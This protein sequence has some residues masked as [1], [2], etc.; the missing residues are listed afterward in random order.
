[1]THRGVS[2][3]SPQEIVPQEIVPQATGDPSHTPTPTLN[4]IDHL[5]RDNHSPSSLSFLDLHTTTTNGP[6]PPKQQARTADRDTDCSLSDNE[7]SRNL[8]R[9]ELRGTTKL[10]SSVL[11]IDIGGPCPTIDDNLHDNLQKI[12]RL[13]QQP[14]ANG[15]FKASVVNGSSKG[16][17]VSDSHRNAVTN[18]RGGDGT[19][20][21]NLKDDNHVLRSRTAS[22]L[23][24]RPYP[25]N[26]KPVSKLS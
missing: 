8:R 18:H 15:N 21:N 10:E 16:S 11:P 5:P 19:S 4:N 24:V 9:R 3:N 12:Q 17:P 14:S 7:V 22:N 23:R 26:H 20:T 13:K 25:V 2:S 1:M 6:I